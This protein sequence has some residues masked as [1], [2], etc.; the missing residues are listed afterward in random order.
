MP[1]PL[2]R[3]TPSCS[4]LLRVLA[5]ETRLGILRHLADGAR[6]V[7]ELQEELDVDR[8]LLSH[9]LRVLRQAG[10][11]DAHREGKTVRYS[12]LPRVLVQRRGAERIDLGCC[13]LVFP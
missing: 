12:V 1:G 13:E 5:D 10:F 11:V 7:F 8:S 6:C 9:H 4:E 3:K 2:R